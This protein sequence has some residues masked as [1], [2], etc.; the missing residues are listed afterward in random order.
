MYC[1]QVPPAGELT[2]GGVTVLA[3]R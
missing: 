2:T 1:T 3:Y